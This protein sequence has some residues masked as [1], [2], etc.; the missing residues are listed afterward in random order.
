MSDRIPRDRADDHT[1]AMARRRRE[2]ARDKTGVALE[3]VRQ[4]GF[5]PAVTTGNVE[6]F[7]GV[8]QVPLGLAGP[9]RIDGEHAKGDFYVAMATSEGALVASY[10][11]GMRLLREVGGATV[12]VVDAAMQRAPVFIFD[13]ARRARARL[14]RVGRATLR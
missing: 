10:N 14:R 7:I 5:D 12:S 4:Y 8:A 9:L 3:H 13:D 6:N 1:E 2:F 11:R